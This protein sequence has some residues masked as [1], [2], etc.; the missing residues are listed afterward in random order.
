ARDVITEYGFTHSFIHSTG[1]GV[2]VEVHEPP[3]IYAT[4]NEILKRGH[5]ITIEPGVYIDGVGGVRIED[6]VYIDG[7]GVVMNRFPHIP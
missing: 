3:R 1:H 7:G 5:V 2:G 6:M 4:S